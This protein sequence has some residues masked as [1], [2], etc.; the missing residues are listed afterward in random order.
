MHSAGGGKARVR[1]GR[2]CAEGRGSNGAGTQSDGVPD[3]S[4]MHRRYSPPP[5]GGG[6]QTCHERPSGR[7]RVPGGGGGAEE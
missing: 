1:G 2:A 4:R 7:R 3:C 5:R 6:A